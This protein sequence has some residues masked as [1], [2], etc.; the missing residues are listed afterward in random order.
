MSASASAVLASRLAAARAGSSEA[1][2]QSLEPFREYLL[3]VARQAVAP[4]LKPKG[5]ASD[6]VQE[7]FLEAQR[8]FPRF[9]GGSSAQL[10]AW[11]RASFCTKPPSSAAVMARRQNGNCRAKCRSVGMTGRFIRAKSPLPSRPPAWRPCRPSSRCSCGRPLTGFPTTIGESWPCATPRACR[12]T[13]WDNNWTGRPTL[14]GCC[15][16]ERWSG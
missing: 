5:G 9:D 4:A 8:L 7:T 11:L 13:R 3:E 2:G 12:L 15:G 1:L 16:P 14:P 6:L 10:R